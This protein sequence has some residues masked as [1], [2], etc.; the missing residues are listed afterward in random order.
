[1]VL[2]IGGLS[3]TYRIFNIQKIHRVNF[4]ISDSVV[5]VLNGVFVQNDQFAVGQNLPADSAKNLAGRRTTCPESG[6]GLD[7][8]R[9]KCYTVWGQGF[10][11]LRW[12]FRTGFLYNSPISPYTNT[13]PGKIL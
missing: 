10:G 13:L 3:N 6:P 9:K 4:G 2:K 8:S 1:M 11:S 7:L 5:H 12:H